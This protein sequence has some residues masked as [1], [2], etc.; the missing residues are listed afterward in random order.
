MMEGKTYSSSSDGDGAPRAEGRPTTNYA[1]ILHTNVGIEAKVAKHPCSVTAM[2]K[3]NPNLPNTNLVALG[4]V[5]RP[6]KSRSFLPSN[7]EEGTRGKGSC[8]DRR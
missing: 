7:I 1:E 6:S 8:R 4:Y 2:G 5:H 3:L